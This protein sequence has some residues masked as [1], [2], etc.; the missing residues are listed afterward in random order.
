MSTSP[1]RRRS[2]GVRGVGNRSGVLD[3]EDGVR[4]LWA[5]RWS[6]PA[7]ADRLGCTDRT[8]SRIRR[9]LGLGAWQKGQQMHQLRRVL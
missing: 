8:V 1:V 6:D 3:R 2:E 7:I 9:R 5:W 4:Q